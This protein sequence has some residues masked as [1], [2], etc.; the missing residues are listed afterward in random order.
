MH[1]EL[2]HF[3]ALDRIAGR[4]I[5]PLFFLKKHFYLGLSKQSL[6]VLL[7]D[8]QCHLNPP[9]ETLVLPSPTPKRLKTF[10]FGGLEP[11]PKSFPGRPGL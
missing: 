7:R 5:L 11:P 9:A 2:I 1:A 6:C 10:V 3:N 4:D 8:L